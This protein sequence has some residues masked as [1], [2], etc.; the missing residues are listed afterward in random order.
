MASSSDSSTMVRGAALAFHRSMFAELFNSDGLLVGA[1]GLG[2]TTT[3]FAKFLKLYTG[4]AQLVLVLNG[5]H[6]VITP[7]VLCVCSF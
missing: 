2:A 7:C 4:G 6:Q 1:R 3:V 5:T